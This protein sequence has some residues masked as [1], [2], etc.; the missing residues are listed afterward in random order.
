MLQHDCKG[1]IL[2]VKV[3]NYQ[4]QH[5][6]FGAARSTHAKTASDGKE[7]TQNDEDDGHCWK[8]T[9]EIK[10]IA[11]F[12]VICLCVVQTGRPAKYNCTLSS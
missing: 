8:N 6:F 3:N 5:P 2:R 9:S 12:A 7:E 10:R 11:S 4:N 1:A